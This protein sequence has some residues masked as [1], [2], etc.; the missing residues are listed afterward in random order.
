MSQQ[1]LD[2]LLA[3]TMPDPDGGGVLTVPVR[4]VVI[5]CDL[6]RAAPDLLS[7]LDLG[8]HLSVVMDPAS[9]TAMGSAVAQALATRY[10]VNAIVMELAPHPDMDAVRRVMAQVSGADGLVAVGS[11]SINDITKHAAHLT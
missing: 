3:G 8:S 6:A 7:K 1:T 5:D 2:R 4:S 11:G 10:Q 9:A